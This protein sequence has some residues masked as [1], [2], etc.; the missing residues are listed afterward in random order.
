MISITKPSPSTAS[1]LKFGSKKL[2]PANPL[3]RLDLDRARGQYLLADRGWK[4]G[5]AG[6][7]PAKIGYPGA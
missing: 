2:S 6:A 5:E 7:S 1:P 4:A 3:L